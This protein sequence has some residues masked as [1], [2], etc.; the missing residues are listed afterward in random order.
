MKMSDNTPVTT[1]DIPL[2]KELTTTP[3][4]RGRRLKTVAGFAK[5]SEVNVHEFE[6][7]H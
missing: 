1:L 3:S 7:G 6:A 4:L 5:L 2:S